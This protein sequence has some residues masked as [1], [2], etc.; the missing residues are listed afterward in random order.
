MA[1]DISIA[2]AA[3]AWSEQLTQTEPEPWSTGRGILIL[4][5]AMS[6][7]YA[8][9]V[10]RFTSGAEA[11][12]AIL[13]LVGMSLWLRLQIWLGRAHVPERY[14]RLLSTILQ[15]GI[16]TGLTLALVLTVEVYSRNRAA[17]AEVSNSK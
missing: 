1:A 8:S 2:S 13:A 17:A 5:G 10:W 15:A 7:W 14:S 9:L 11:L 4:A 12:A 6:I 3:Q 16:P